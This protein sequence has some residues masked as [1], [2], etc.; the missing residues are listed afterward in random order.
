VVVAVEEVVQ[1]IVVVAENVEY[2]IIPVLLL[3]M[4]TIQEALAE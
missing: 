4:T 2:I 1:W 3:C